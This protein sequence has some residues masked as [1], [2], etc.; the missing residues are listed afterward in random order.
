MSFK[1]RIVAALAVTTA[2]VLHASAQAVVIPVDQD[3]MTSAFLQ[4][5][6]LVRGYPGDTR[7]TFRVA[8]D[9]A[10]GV[11]PETIYLSFDS[12]QF[13]GFTSPVASAIL[14]MESTAGGFGADADPNS[15]FTVSAHAVDT[16][17]LVAIID[18]TNPGGTIDWLTFF[19]NNILP[20]DSAALTVVDSFGPVAFD[21]TAVVNDW[22][23]GANTVFALAM[24]GKNDTSGNDILH[25]FLN[26]H[27]AG[28]PLGVSFLTVT[29]PEPS[30]LILGALGLV[31]VVMQRRRTN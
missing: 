12:A 25:G 15:P 13:S 21:V 14:T 16:D 28:A 6:D 8:T 9:N 26:N 30:A 4:G 23:S 22:I 20:A 18:D 17:P 1:N 24:T 7:P 27:D 3:V 5:T 10:F 11:G 29:V 31:G 2:F 19:G